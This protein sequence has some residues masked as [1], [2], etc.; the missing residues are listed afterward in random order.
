VW[1]SNTFATWLVTVMVTGD[2]MVLAPRLSVA[3]A[4]RV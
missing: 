3:V 4:V 1:I 2:E